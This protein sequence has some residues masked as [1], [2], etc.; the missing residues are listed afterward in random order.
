MGWDGPLTHRQFIV[1]QVWLNQQKNMPSR[2]NYYQMQIAREVRRQYSK[3]PNKVQTEEFKIKF[4]YADSLSQELLTDDEHK[5][6]IK[7][8]KR[9]LIAF[10]TAPIT[11]RKDGQEV[12][13]I[14]PPLVKRKQL[15][16][17]RQNKLKQIKKPS[18][19]QPLNR[20]PRKSR[21]LDT[22]ET[23]KNENTNG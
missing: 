5:E 9:R 17:E 2:D 4:V 13:T 1:W 19:R 8:T 20:H 16:E 18:D 23:R 21:K 6:Q 7:E 22:K 12:E 15:M 3:K 11:V 14:I 10:M